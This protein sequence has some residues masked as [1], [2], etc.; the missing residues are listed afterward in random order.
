MTEIDLLKRVRDD[1]PAPDPLALARARQRL[2]TPPPVR[3]CV[4]RGR[5][6]VAG[7]LALTLA[8]GFLAADVVG[9]ESSPLPG[10]AADASTFLANAA[11]LV[12]AGPDTPI[13]PGQYRLVTTEV[14]RM[15]EFGPGKKYRAMVNGATNEWIPADPTTRRH[16]LQTQELTKVEFTTPE[17][18]AA[19]RRLAPVLFT[20]PK[21][22]LYAANCHGIIIQSSL[23]PEVLNRPCIPGWSLPTAEFLARQ[24]RDPDKLLTALRNAPLLDHPPSN[25][26]EQARVENTPPDEIAFGRIAA[27][28]ELGVAPAD[29]RAALYQAAAKLPGIVLIDDVVTIAGKH[30]R[31]IGYERHGQRQDIIISPTDG[32]SIGSRW[33]VTQ[34]GADLDKANLT[35]NARP[36]DLDMATSVTSRITSRAP[37]IK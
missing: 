12:K 9:H 25:P 14:S 36:G 1:V 19:A 30:G 34:E 26:L 37:A 20:H 22:T 2:F 27:V 29:L 16:P 8:G 31:A 6:L 32:Q 4:T 3:R 5:L 13:R 17:A 11:A 15:Y 18:R 28:L 10:T 21:P 7:G 24:P 33:V 23:S 35:G